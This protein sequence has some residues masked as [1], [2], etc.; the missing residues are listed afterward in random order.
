MSVF[1]HFTSLSAFRE[2]QRKKIVRPR[3]RMLALGTPCA[4][5]KKCLANE[6]AI[7]GVL[8]PDAPEWWQ[9]EFGADQPLMETVLKD[10]DTGR[11]ADGDEEQIV[12]LKIDLAPE[13]HVYIAD[14]GVHLAEDYYGTSFNHRTKTPNTPKEVVA[15]VKGQYA[16]SL[17]PIEEYNPSL[18]YAVPE[19]VCFSEIPASRVT[20]ILQD[21][22]SEM[23]RRMREAYGLSEPQWLWVPEV[24]ACVM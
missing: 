8:D 23:I 15:R 3:R 13:D 17:V 11:L 6:G 10:I 22:R 24:Y 14:W 16:D 20:R 12:V 18:S 2:I 7:F 9:N 5:D 4:S 19:V 1:Y 21:N